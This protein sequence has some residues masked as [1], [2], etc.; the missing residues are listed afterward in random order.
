LI[1]ETG[2]VMKFSAGR[3]HIGWLSFTQLFNG[4]TVQYDSIAARPVDSW[5]YDEVEVIGGPSTFLF[6]AGAVGGSI[7]Y[8]TRM[9]TLARDAFD[10]RVAYGSYNASELSVGVNRR[11]KG[12]GCD[13]RCEPTSA[14]RTRM[15]RSTATSA[16]PGPPRSRC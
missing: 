12:A 8:I 1:A 6:G 7:K 11:L 5:I 2:S 16:E 9:P 4:I 14:G 15:A 13:T 10:A 3:N